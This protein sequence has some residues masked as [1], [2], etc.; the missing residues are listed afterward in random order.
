MKN[1]K[2]V[3]KTAKK[4]ENNETV[5]LEYQE[6]SNRELEAVAGGKLPPKDEQ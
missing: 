1:N 4:L 3:T 2:A 5:K 6:L